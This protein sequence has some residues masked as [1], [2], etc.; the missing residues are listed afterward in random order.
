M[1]ICIRESKM[2]VKE[3]ISIVS[4]NEINFRLGLKKLLAAKSPIASAIS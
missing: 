1:R 3:F 4:G 2:D